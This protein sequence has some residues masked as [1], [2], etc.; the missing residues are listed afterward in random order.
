M[1]KTGFVFKNL[2]RRKVRTTLTLLSVTCA[3]LLFG[4]LQAINV[5]LQADVSFV[6]A[7]RLI[8]QARVSFT[9]PLPIRLLPQIEA[10]P[11]VQAVA[12]SLWFGGLLGENSP[13]FAFAVTPERLRS[14]SPQWQMPEEQWR[15]FGTSRTSMIAGRMLAQQQGWKVGSR[16]PIKSNI[17]PQHNGSRDW[18]FDLVGIFDGR[19]EAAQ[20]Q[21]L[22]A[23]INYAYIDEANQFGPGMAGFF[24]VRVADPNQAQT[25]AQSI[26]KMF[27]N[28][29]DETKTQTEQDFVLAFIKQIGDIG[30]IVRW[31]LFAVFFTLLLVVGN[32]MAQA[33]RERIPEL[34]V[35]KTLGFSNNSVLGFVL[36]ESAILCTLGGLIGLGLATLGGIAA[37]RAT[38]V[39]VAV[40][41]RVWAAGVLAIL[42]LSLAVGLLPALRARRL[43]IVDALAA[44]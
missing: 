36:A 34:A 44:R 1:T 41:Y 12:N 8:T 38:N 30:M 24:I 15:A 40:D 20:K 28:S 7:T 29:A 13:M 6:G 31:I 43:S 17:F 21:T 2:F 9:Q 3:F 14:V 25:V 22:R 37:A 39:P 33:V 26:D 5:L 35:M 11:G 23:Y 32:T 4:L 16:I 42:L 10:V 27:E 18:A 19:D